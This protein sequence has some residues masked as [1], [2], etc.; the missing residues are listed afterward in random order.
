[1]PDTGQLSKSSKRQKVT[2][3]ETLPEKSSSKVPQIFTSFRAIGIVANHV[4]PTIQ[5]LGKTYHVTTCVGKSFQT[6]DVH[7]HSVFF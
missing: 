6:Y 3:K 1:M 7:T 4:P 5:V 2:P